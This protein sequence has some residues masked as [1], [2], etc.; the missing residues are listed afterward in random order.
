MKTRL[1]NFFL[2][3]NVLNLT[4]LQVHLRKG[5]FFKSTVTKNYVDILKLIIFQQIISYLKE[6]TFV[7]LFVYFFV[8]ATGAIKKPKAPL[9]MKTLQALKGRFKR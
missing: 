7:N 8:L 1:K 5:F 3:L 9:M 2:I 6:K 4:F